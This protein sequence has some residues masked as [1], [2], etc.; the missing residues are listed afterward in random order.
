MNV[1]MN[2]WTEYSLREP[3]AFLHECAIPLGS[4]GT[5]YQSDVLFPSGNPDPAVMDAI[6]VVN[7]RILE[8]DPFVKGSTP[9]KDTAILHSADSVWSKEPLIPTPGWPPGPA[10]YSA[11]GA[12]KALIEGHVQNAI[13]NSE[14]LVDTLADYRALILADQR[15]LSEDECNAI[16]RFVRDGGVVFATCET[17]T[18]D[19]NNKLLDTFSLSDV[20]GVDYRETSDTAN[21]YLRMKSKDTTFG[22]PAM[23]IQ[24]GGK[25]TRVKTTTAKTVLELVPPYEDIK[26]GTPPPAENPEGPGVTVHSY[27]R[28]KAVYCCAQLFDAYYRIATP[29]IRKLALWMLDRVYPSAQR[30]IVCE[31]TPINVE[32]FYNRRGTER[33][34][35]LVN[36][37]GDKRGNGVPQT[38]DFPVVH[39]IQ[40]HI[41]TDVKPSSVD[42]VPEG[43]KVRF[44][45][46]N[47][48]ISFEAEPLHIHNVYRIV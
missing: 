44:A 10:Y 41:K 31:N 8:L 2:N 12:H 17:S 14:G 27:G 25:Y 7:R 46:R 45:Y 26:T 9:V 39:G 29:V 23:D 20:F 43:R 32:V 38:Q 15:I 42:V 28:G 37:S 21:C 3:E 47:G 35:H 11:C 4:C 33:F 16:R 36:Y 34:V 19:S 18:R 13:L 24:V 5:L 30:S 48:M 6:G 40:V 1:R 22:I